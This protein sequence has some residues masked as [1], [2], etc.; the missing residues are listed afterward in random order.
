MKPTAAPLLDSDALC[1]QPWQRPLVRGALALL[2][3]CLRLGAFNQAYDQL[4]QAPASDN[5]FETS[6]N[7][8][9][10]RY[11]VSESDLQRIPRQGPVV[12]V[13]NHP[14][15]GLDG[16]ILGAILQRVRP[17]SRLLV[18]H[19]LGRIP[20]LKPHLIE[21]DPFG[22]QG[23]AASN[24]RPMRACIRHLE[25]GGLLAVWPAG[26]VSH[27]H[28]RKGRVTDPTWSTHI[29][30]LVR[31]TG[32]T[33]VPVHFSGRNS[34]FFQAAGL[35][36]PLLRTALLP[37]EL[38]GMRGKSVSLAIGQPL[39]AARLAKFEDA[40]ELISYL[41]L[42][43]YILGARGL[44]ERKP[45]RLGLKL[46]PTLLEPLAAPQAPEILRQEVA[47]LPERQRLVEQ[48]EFQVY[49]ARAGQIP[50]VLREIGR[51]RE[52]T[53]RGVGEGTGKALDL[54]RFDAHYLHLFLWNKAVGELAGAYR[55]GASDRILPEFG[56]DGLYTTTLFRY[57]SGF[58]D[59]LGPAL[60]MGR[61]FITPDYQRRAAP[62]GLLWRGIGQYC[63]QNPR[64]RTLFGPVS[65][66]GDY[67]RLSRRL[68]VTYLREQALNREAA[69]SVQAK[70]PPRGSG[71]ELLDRSAFRRSVRDIED[72]SA[73]IS[74]IEP[75]ARGVPVLL[76][77][78][79]KLN[80]TMLSF[81]VDPDFMD[82]IDGLVLVDLTRTCP[83]T[84]RR[85]MGDSG[86]ERFMEYHKAGV[87]SEA[88]PLG[89]MPS[90]SG[91]L[92]QFADFLRGGG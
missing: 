78:Y 77:Q 17:D 45:L 80:G 64:Y 46:R 16:V 79:L 10:I 87:D 42:K 90:R 50:A 69:R 43:T 9:G 3:P 84:L 15:G 47:D 85:Y 2:E 44:Q 54:D 51:L 71:L 57:R 19:L 53:F 60:E 67:R 27:F 91:N 82:C 23:A 7:S 41:R 24:L 89:R 39:D 36:H 72:V 11:E 75:E 81:N 55:L 25:D 40:A 13:C 34:L 49:I 76:R 62:L 28:L 52:L 14:F 5:F 59:S 4:R 29:A 32:A 8:L 70:R 63:A 66:S 58:L 65:I 22:G 30:T 20:E 35:V 61:S 74:E 38:L 33:V 26:T 86:W 37:R 12:V 48:G 68:M 88:L 92:A 73:L 18:N 56:D 83:K 31:R 6:L 21:V 1:T